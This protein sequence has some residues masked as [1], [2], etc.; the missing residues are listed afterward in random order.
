MKFFF[1]FFALSFFIAGMAS[2]SWRDDWR[3]Q[4]PI[5]IEPIPPIP[6]IDISP[7]RREQIR[8]EAPRSPLISAPPFYVHHRHFGHH[9]D[10][11]SHYFHRRYPVVRYEIHSRFPFPQTIEVV[12][13]SYEEEFEQYRRDL[14]D[15]EIS[16]EILGIK[17]SA[18]VRN[19]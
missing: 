14:P 12:R 19:Y 6:P 13:P 18:R 10:H 8:I 16:G 15:G 2:A 7:G 9:C 1:L 5:S 11:A 3:A 4:A 17:F